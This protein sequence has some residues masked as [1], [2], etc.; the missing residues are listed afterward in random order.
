MTLAERCRRFALHR[1]VSQFRRPRGL[2]GR[3][4]GWE[5]TLRP[6]NRKRSNWAVCLLDLQPT[7]R[8]PEIGFGPGLAIRDLARRATGGIVVGIDHSEAMAAQAAR[9]N[10]RAIRQARVSVM[11]AS[12]ESLPGFDR[13]FHK[14]LA[15]N[16]WACGQTKASPERARGHAAAGRLIAIVSQPRCPGAMAD[17][18]PAA[19]AEIVGLLQSAGFVAIRVEPLKLAPPVAG[20]IGT[21]ADSATTSGR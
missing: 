21:A 14:I 18:T 10:A 5:M 13:P 20:V 11:V 3:L 17:T 6:S 8:V 1:V 2:A 15:V 7:D 16:A 4:V 19:A 9:R 12:I